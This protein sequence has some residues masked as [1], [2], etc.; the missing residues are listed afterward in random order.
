[1]AGI[2]GAR[3]GSNTSQ[4]RSERMEDVK[5]SAEAVSVDR[6]RSCRLYPSLPKVDRHEVSMLEGAAAHRLQSRST[7]TQA[8]SDT[9]L[10]A[11][12][13]ILE[14]QKKELLLINEKWARE[15]R[16]MK[17]FYS[18]KVRELRS[19]LQG[20]FSHTED[21]R[22][23]E[24]EKNITFGKKVQD[25]DSAK[26]EV[27]RSGDEAAELRG[28]NSFLT[29]RGQHQMQE[30]RRL[31]EALQV[32]LGSD[33]VRRASLQDVWKHQAEVYREDFLKERSDREKLHGRYLD[34]EEKYRKVCYELRALKPQAPPTKP[35]VDCRCRNHGRSRNPTEQ[36][37]HRPTHALNFT[38][39]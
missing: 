20:D 7:D 2:N 22:C 8:D 38:H 16:T 31:N 1:M 26:A 32:V 3:S 9:T 10:A 12:I 11:Q 35:I 5:S 28:Q 29:R 30:I 24:G 14:E 17:Q 36:P 25:E 27:S 21:N 15:Y 13:L 19:I 37:T 4:N 6:K 18:K 33:D 34:L 39:H 23:E